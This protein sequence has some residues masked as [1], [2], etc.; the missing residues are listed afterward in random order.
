[1]EKRRREWYE[2]D[3]VNS[4]SEWCK[5]K[6]I[7]KSLVWLWENKRFDGQRKRV[8]GSGFVVTREEGERWSDLV[9]FGLD[10]VY[11]V[12]CL[13]QFRFVRLLLRFKIFEFGLTKPAFVGK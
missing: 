13:V 4:I 12:L 1:M 8:D 9:C 2:G 10:M 7:I 5:K 11:L 3:D 6:K